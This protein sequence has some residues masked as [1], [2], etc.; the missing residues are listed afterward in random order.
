MI[1]ISDVF[2]NFMVEPILVHKNEKIK[3]I[4]KKFI[5][6]KVPICRCAYVIDDYKQIVGRIT[7]RKIMNYVAIK[8]ALT[9]NKPYSVNTLFQYISPDLVAEN[10]MGPAIV[11]DI[12]QSLEEA[13]QLMLDKNVEEAAVVDKDGHVLGDLNIYE[14]LKKIEID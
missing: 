8:K 4:H 1:T 11:V 3:S 2:K 6:Q 12:D 10:I 9:G 13:F 7:L 14:V 5:M